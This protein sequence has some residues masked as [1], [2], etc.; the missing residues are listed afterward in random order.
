[1]AEIIEETRTRIRQQFRAVRRALKDFASDD[2]LFEEKTA[3]N[4]ERVKKELAELEKIT[5]G[6]TAPMEIQTFFQTVGEGVIAA[7]KALDERSKQYLDSRPVHVL[8]S[9]F[10]IPKASAEIQFAIESTET[11]KFS[12]LVFGSSDSRQQSQQHKVSFDIVAAPPPPDIM[13]KLSELPLRALL[14]ANRDER[15]I[16]R[17]KVSDF[18]QTVSGGIRKKAQ[19]FAKEE[20]FRK[21]LVLR[22]N[23]L[24]ALLLPT[25]TQG[26]PNLDVAY[27]PYEGTDVMVDSRDPLPQSPPRLHRLFKLFSDLSEDQERLLREQ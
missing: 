18:A 23:E 22:G 3:K 14:V 21:V 5:P 17:E 6:A 2:E 12:V 20:T 8:P 16:A 26:R 15:R 9:V 10:R 25:A 27:V 7:Q 13:A 19:K 24:W 1:M 11:E 4:L